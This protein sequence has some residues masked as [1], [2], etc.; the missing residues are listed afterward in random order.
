MPVPYLKSLSKETGK[1][2]SELEKLWGKAK[3]IASEHFNKPESEFGD[4]E[5]AY[6]VGVVKKMVK[7]VKEGHYE[8]LD[9]GLKAPMSEW[10]FALD[11]NGRR[12]EKFDDVDSLKAQLKYYGLPD[13]LA[14]FN[15]SRFDKEG[16]YIKN[17]YRSSAIYA[18]PPVKYGK[19]IE[20]C[21]NN[22]VEILTV[23]EDTKIPGTRF[24]IKKGQKFEFSIVDE[25]AS[26]LENVQAQVVK[27]FKSVNGL[28]VKDTKLEL[29][30]HSWGPDS[31]LSIEVEWD[32]GVDLKK[33]EPQINT[34]C[35]RFPEVHWDYYDFPDFPIRWYYFYES[36]TQE[37]IEITKEC[38]IPGAGI[39]L[40]EGDK[41]QLVESVD[42]RIGV[43]RISDKEQ[44]P[45]EERIKELRGF[46]HD[47]YM[48]NRDVILEVKRAKLNTVKEIQSY[49]EA[50]EAMIRNLNEI[51]EYEDE[52]WDLER[53]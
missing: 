36:S 11:Y 4:T 6:V 51:K 49:I 21:E 41:I 50:F 20:N 23:T 45:N 47:L 28:Y 34:I 46:I 42:R 24:T 33:L 35:K 31:K 10:N 48:A 22:D 40:E 27:L 37:C 25:A 12:W 5:F 16:C 44:N 38:S 17:S 19:W 26:S 30:K 43:Y 32:D 9:Y 8:I 1:S 2:I 53:K 14:I 3:K 13:S 52:I 39:V 15:V 7:D 29:K 18:Y